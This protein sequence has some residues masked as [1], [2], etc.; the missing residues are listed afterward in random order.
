VAFVELNYEGD[1]KKSDA[2]WSM[3]R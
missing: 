1:V 2:D 3:R